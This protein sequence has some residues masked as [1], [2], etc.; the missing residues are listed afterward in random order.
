MSKPDGYIGTLSVT[1]ENGQKNDFEISLSGNRLWIG[2][3]AVSVSN[4]K[5]FRGIL[6]EISEV[7]NSTPQNVKQYTWKELTRPLQFPK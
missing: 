5:T 2:S 1:W 7:L 3:H 4:E 6:R